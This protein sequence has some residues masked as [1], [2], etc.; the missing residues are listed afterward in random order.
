MLQTFTIIT[1]SFRKLWDNPWM[2]LMHCEHVWVMI[3]SV[4]DV[5]VSTCWQFYNGRSMFAPYSDIDLLL[6]Q[7]TDLMGCFF[8]SS[9]P[10]L[11]LVC[12]PVLWT[13]Q[14]SLNLG[15]GSISEMRGRGGRVGW[16]R[17]IEL[18]FQV[19]I[20]STDP[21]LV[22]TLALTHTRMPVPRKRLHC[23]F[24]HKLTD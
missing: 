12:S 19:W 3:I 24:T 5:L 15:Q 17:L 8:C 10:L 9:L 21:A 20:Y 4:V 14:L 6:D 16:E 1:T 13:L 22:Y 18:L 2:N 7:D 11:K 23:E